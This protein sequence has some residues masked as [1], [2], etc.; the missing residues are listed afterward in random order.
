MGS[1]RY[2]AGTGL[3]VSPSRK[4]LLVWIQVATLLKSAEAAECIEGANTYSGLAG[5]SPCSEPATEDSFEGDS[6]YTGRY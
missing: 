6:G 4:D 5:Q 1:A 3:T 2:D